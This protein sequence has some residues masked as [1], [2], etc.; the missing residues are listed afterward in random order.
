MMR[1]NLFKLSYDLSRHYI[2]VVVFEIKLLNNK[3][4][5]EDDLPY[6]QKT[7]TVNLKL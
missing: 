3:P 2:A 7:Y 5:C 6:F 1:E 4:K